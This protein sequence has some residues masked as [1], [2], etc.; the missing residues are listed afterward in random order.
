LNNGPVLFARDR[1]PFAT[2]SSF[3]RDSEAG[4]PPQA[5]RIFVR[6]RPNPLVTPIRAILDTAAPWCILRP[7]IGALIADELEAV[8][9]SVKLS[10]RL[11]VFEGRL[12]RGLLTLLA[13]KGE[14]LDLEVT[15]FLSPLWRGPNFLGYEGA[16]DRIRFAVDPHAN[17]FYFGETD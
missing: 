9:G 16:L 6:V 8:S 15:Y 12:Y 1:S 3:Y 7:Q 10:S 13:E 4:A 2:G 11:G 17:L 14:S 5:P